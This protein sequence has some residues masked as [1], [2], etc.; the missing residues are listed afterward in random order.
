MDSLLNGPTDSDLATSVLQSLDLNSFDSGV[1]DMKDTSIAGKSPKTGD[2]LL[3]QAAVQASTWTNMSTGQSHGGKPV[4][5]APNFPSKTSSSPENVTSQPI[6]RQYGFISTSVQGGNQIPHQY[7]DKPA[8]TIRLDFHGG[9]LPRRA[10]DEE[11][12]RPVR[13]AEKR[14]AEF[15]TEI[16][17]ECHRFLFTQQLW[18]PENNDSE[19]EK[20]QR[21]F[22]GGP[23]YP[24]NR[25]Y[26]DPVQPDIAFKVQDKRKWNTIVSSDNDR[27]RRVSQSSRRRKSF[28][29]IF[30]LRINRLKLSF[31]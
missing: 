12:H 21:Q 6:R 10:P 20:F 7:D 5:L 18:P 23:I 2:G 15:G 16:T 30:L 8:N 24:V 19:I 9:V 26:D 1:G 25:I 27:N 14:R 11:F 13:F 29:G 4:K 17:H 28:Q 3:L 31:Y 22:P